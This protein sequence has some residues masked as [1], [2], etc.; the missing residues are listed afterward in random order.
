MFKMFRKLNFLPPFDWIFIRLKH[1]RL[2]TMNDYT[3]ATNFDR[4]VAEMHD[5]LKLIEQKMKGMN[6]TVGD[7][8]DMESAIKKQIVSHLAI[9]QRKN[10]EG[11]HIFKTISMCC[12]Y[13]TFIILEP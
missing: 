1:S 12:Y 8:D 6:F 4:K 9:F 11:V 3:S 2:V 7:N 10:R 13:S 5:W